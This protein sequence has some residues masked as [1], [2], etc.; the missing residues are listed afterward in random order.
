M[1]KDIE[2]MDSELKEQLPPNSNMLFH[3]IQ[4][5]RR[6]N[7]IYWEHQRQLSDKNNAKRERERQDVVKRA[8]FRQQ[9]GIELGGLPGVMGLGLDMPENPVAKA[10]EQVKGPQK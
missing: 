7:E 9:H 4:F 5:I 1:Y 10:E 6:W 8:E 3:P 2:S